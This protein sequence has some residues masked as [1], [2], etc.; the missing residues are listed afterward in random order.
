MV[1]PLSPY[2][3]QARTLPHDASVECRFVLCWR[4]QVQC[5]PS[6][7]PALQHLRFAP[8]VPPLCSVLCCLCARRSVTAHS[9]CP[10]CLKCSY[11]AFKRALSLPLETIAHLQAYVLQLSDQGLALID[12]L[13]T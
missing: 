6:S 13:V 9:V 11:T 5:R 3:V 2:L 4:S 10:L 12:S 8:P 1:R 7:L